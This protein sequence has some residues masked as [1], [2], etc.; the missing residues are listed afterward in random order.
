M[1]AK[2][3]LCLMLIILG[4]LT[5]Q[6]AIPR[7]K[8]KNPLEVSARQIRECFFDPLM[9]TFFIITFYLRSWTLVCVCRD[10][11]VTLIANM[12][13]TFSYLQNAMTLGLAGTVSL[14]FPV[15]KSLYTAQNTFAHKLNHFAAPL[16]S[17]RV[18]I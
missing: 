18:W 8:K 10:Q 14:N 11:Q 5:V 3:C 7:N 12:Q 17:N 16:N 4:T 1:D 9:S 13:T 15:K 2:L 6:G